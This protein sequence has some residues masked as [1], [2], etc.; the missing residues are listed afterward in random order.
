MLCIGVAAVAASPL[1]FSVDVMDYDVAWYDHPPL[2][3]PEGPKAVFTVE[4]LYAAFKINGDYSNRNESNPMFVID[5]KVVLNITNLSDRKAKMTHADFAAAED[6]KVV[7]AVI[8]DA[9]FSGTG[10]TLTRSCGGMIEGVW[11]DD[12]WINTTWIPG[13]DYPHNLF[14][15]IKQEHTVTTAIPDLPPNATEEGTWVNAVP[16]AQYCNANGIVAVHM[17]INGTWVDVT[18]R[19]KAEPEQPFLMGSNTLLG[20][21]STFS[22]ERYPVD[23]QNLSSFN[24]TA[25]PSQLWTMGSNGLVYRWAYGMDGNRGFD[26]TWKPKQSRLIML[27]GL[28]TVFSTSGFD[29]LESEEITLYAAVANY[30]SNPP[31]N[32]IQFDN[33]LT[34]FW[35]KRVRVEQTP[36]GYVY[37]NV[38]SSDQ[39]F[40]TDASGL[41]VFV[42][43]KSSLNENP[44]L[45][46]WT[47][48]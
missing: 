13:T 6:I 23:Y 44:P 26:C 45:R 8:A 11:L 10:G 38:L 21:I 22:V 31:V 27:S 34:A 18:G 3:T 17:Y 28:L 7:P 41:E 33:S 1:L 29:A 24:M 2:G 40:Q 30:V 46:N 32:G 36:E 37:N 9:F 14:R 48:G 43:P 47:T 42:V 39:T 12:Q 15:E 5:Y 19:V 4:I 20:C 25:I 16:I 35:I